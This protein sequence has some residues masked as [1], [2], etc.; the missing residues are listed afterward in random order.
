MAW[1]DVVEPRTLRA[2]R[3]ALGQSQAAFAAMLG[4]SPE[5]YRTWNAGRRATPLK[6]LAR[7]RALA[8]HRDDH[9]LDRNPC[10]TAA[11]P[12]SLISW[13]SVASESGFPRSQLP[14]QVL[15]CPR[16]RC[17]RG[18]FRSEDPTP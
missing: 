17:V 5:S 9:E 11:M 18:G 12:S 13:L 15:D 6:I 10:G 14:I 3:I 1:C 16:L 8:T 7:A 4:V 2:C